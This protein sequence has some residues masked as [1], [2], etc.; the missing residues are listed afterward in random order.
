MCF[1]IDF[2]F[3]QKRFDLFLLIINFVKQQKRK[4][5]IYVERLLPMSLAPTYLLLPITLTYI[6]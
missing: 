1:C 4:T 5:I 2:D 3:A 6:T